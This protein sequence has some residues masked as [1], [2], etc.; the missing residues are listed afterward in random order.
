MGSTGRRGPG[1]VR[2][3]RVGALDAF[4][5]L[6]EG[7]L[8]GHGRLAVE[9]LSHGCFLSSQL[10]HETTHPLNL[11]QLTVRGPP[12]DAPKHTSNAPPETTDSRPTANI[13]DLVVPRLAGAILWMVAKSNSH[14]F[15]TM[16]ETISIV[17]IYR[18]NHQ[19]P[20][21]LSAGFCPCTVGRERGN[22]PF[23]GPPKRGFRQLDGLGGHSIFHSPSTSKAMKR[24][25]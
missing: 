23:R 13:K 14:H 10:S 3:H 12:Q 1:A 5:G 11:T 18:G 2:I 19:K 24:V 15:E 9:L 8:H 22:E 7:V 25:K 17:G 21:F 4:L 6:G 16:V 20:G